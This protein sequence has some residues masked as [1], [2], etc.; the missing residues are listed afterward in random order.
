MAAKKSQANSALQAVE[1]SRGQ[2]DLDGG[3]SVAVVSRDGTDEYVEIRASNGRVELSI[4]MTEEG[5]VLQLDG[6]RLSVN[7]AE[8]IDMKC[9]KFSV[10]ASESVELTSEGSLD[11]SSEDEMTVRSTA[12]VRVRGRIIYLN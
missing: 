6:V 11:V 12:D 9:K 8:S 4:K 10:D 3:R 5:P 7:A 2:I 1:G